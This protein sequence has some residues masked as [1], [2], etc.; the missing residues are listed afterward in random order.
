MRLAALLIAAAALPACAHTA[1][2]PPAPSAASAPA[3]AASV[4]L[5]DADGVIKGSVS[6]TDAPKGVLMKLEVW[7]LPPG[8]HGLHFHEKADCSDPAFT[9]AGGHV[10][11]GGTRVHG[12]LN[13]AANEAGDLPNL[14]V[15]DDGKAV[16]ELFSP[17]VSLSG[18]G[19]RAWLRDADGSALVVHANADDHI[20]QPI[21]GAGAR[22]ACGT[23]R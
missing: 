15:G 11:G 6:M 20:T 22:I 16:A 5:R 21:G 13:G 19:G 17:F 1:A 18:S 4:E 10:H 3:A 14:V 7:G 23:I 9:S 8:W 2:E 12:L